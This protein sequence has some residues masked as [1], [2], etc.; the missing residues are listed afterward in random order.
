MRLATL[1]FSTS[2]LS[3]PAFPALGEP[4][5]APRVA[6]A[7][8]PATDARRMVTE[9]CALARK[10]GK[11]CELSIPAEDVGGATPGPGEI[12]VRTLRPGTEPSLIRIRRD[13]VVEIVKSAEDL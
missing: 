8:A 7:P 2:L 3:L 13:F 11:P 5:P 9:D 1:V 10:A 12:N 6:P 4:R